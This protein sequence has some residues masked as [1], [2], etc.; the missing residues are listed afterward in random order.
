MHL[1]DKVCHMTV[2][3]CETISTLYYLVACVHLAAITK[4]KFSFSVW[5]SFISLE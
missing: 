5:L 3:S 1:K 2:Q 4:N